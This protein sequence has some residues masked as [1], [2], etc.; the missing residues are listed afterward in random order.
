MLRC[1]DVLLPLIFSPLFFRAPTTPA[2]S[3]LFAITQ[4]AIAAACCHA[5]R[6]L[7]LPHIIDTL[8]HT[9]LLITSLL[10]ISR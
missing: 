5:L 9:P 6:P 4:D 7:I 1:F 2:A 3:R 8:R 10:I